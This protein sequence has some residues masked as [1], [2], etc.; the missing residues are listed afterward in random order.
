MIGLF[1]LFYLFYFIGVCVYF[2]EKYQWNHGVSRYDGSRW[3][4]LRSDDEGNNIYKDASGNI[5]LI[6]WPSIEKKHQHR[7]NSNQYL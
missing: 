5:I 1:I 4:L 6:S 7:F 3:K 2:F